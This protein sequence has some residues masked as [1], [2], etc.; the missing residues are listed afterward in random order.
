MILSLT[1]CVMRV[2]EE[3]LSRASDESNGC[4]SWDWKKA[5]NISFGRM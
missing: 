4:A 2:G 5:E 1:L 3:V